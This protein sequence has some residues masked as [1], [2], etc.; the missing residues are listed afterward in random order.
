MAE[1]GCE[2]IQVQS[3][4]EEI[5]ELGEVAEDEATTMHLEWQDKMK[6]AEKKIMDIYA[7]HGKITRH[8]TTSTQH[9]LGYVYHAPAIS[10]GT[11]PKQ[12]I[13]D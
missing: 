7:L 9:V 5:G 11:G 6:N 12:F 10:F 2:T 1:I 8:W 3:C 4:E 13:E